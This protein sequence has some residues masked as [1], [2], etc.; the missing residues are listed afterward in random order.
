MSQC[1]VA[2]PAVETGAEGPA[3]Q[4][5]AKAQPM[6]SRVA[7]ALWASGPPQPWIEK[8]RILTYVRAKLERCRRGDRRQGDLG[9]LCLDLAEMQ[10]DEKTKHS[11]IAGSPEFHGIFAGTSNRANL[12]PDFTSRLEIARDIPRRAVRRYNE[13]QTLAR[14][15][16]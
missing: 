2:I 7:C 3:Q 15:G 14:R 10:G 16:L 12:L 6:F 8:Q 9:L 4:V 5:F 1:C 11:M 13:G